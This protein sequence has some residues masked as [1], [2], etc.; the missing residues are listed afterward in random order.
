MW[1]VGPLFFYIKP[2][3]PEC[4]GSEPQNPVDARESNKDD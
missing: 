2:P 4:R 3:L 1:R